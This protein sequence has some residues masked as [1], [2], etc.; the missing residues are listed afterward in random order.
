MTFWN[1]PTETKQN[2][3]KC[4]REPGTS[5]QKSRVLPRHEIHLQKTDIENLH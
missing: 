5:R 1:L 2:N 3:D 4:H